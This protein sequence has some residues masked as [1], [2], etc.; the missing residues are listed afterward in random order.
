MQRL[1]AHR[2]PQ[3]DR[4]VDF[5]KFGACAFAE[6][7]FK[8]GAVNRG[9]LVD[10]R[11]LAQN[12]SDNVECSKTLN[13]PAVGSPAF[14]AL[15]CAKFP[16][17]SVTPRRKDGS[18]FWSSTA[19]IDG[20]EIQAR[21]HKEHL[22]IQARKRAPVLNK[23]E[24]VAVIGETNGMCRHYFTAGPVCPSGQRFVGYAGAVPVCIPESA[25]AESE[26]PACRFV[27]AEQVKCTFDPDLAK[28][29]P[30]C[31]GSLKPR[32]AKITYTTLQGSF[33]CPSGELYGGTV[34]LGL[35]CLSIIGPPLGPCGAWAPSTLMCC[36]K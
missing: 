18:V 12:F 20:L 9:K 15:S 32:C 7:K 13:S 4:R 34:D 17:G 29:L 10:L 25:A 19:A 27:K 1:F 28:Y 6:H 3:C 24:W 11:F 14:T 5:Y 33:C 22:Y 36:R 21:C 35:P 26:R 30:L 2:D 16:M 23:V 8:I 31:D